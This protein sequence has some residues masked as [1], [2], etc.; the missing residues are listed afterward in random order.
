MKKAGV[1]FLLGLIILAVL[2]TAGCVK[3]V[4]EKSVLDIII[5]KDGNLSYCVGDTMTVNLPNYPIDGYSW[6]VTYSD[7]FDIQKNMVTAQELGLDNLY[8]SYTS[9]VFSPNEDAFEDITDKQ[10]A[11]SF[12]LKFMI[13]GEE[14]SAK[15]GYS[16]SMLVVNSDE[17][18]KSTFTYHGD[19]APQR[20]K[21]VSVIFQKTES[22]K[23]NK[24]MT[25]PTLITDGLTLKNT[26]NIMP[27][28][29]YGGEY[30]ATKWIVTSNDLGYYYFGAK[31]Y[32]PNGKDNGRKFYLLVTFG[33]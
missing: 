30:G 22:N 1:F 11:A 26:M 13:D 8:D 32:L 9:F 2:F 23:D 24:Y 21:N 18:T 10:G 14:E 17:H 27:G 4:D 6:E 15:Y 29:L 33:K 5:T 12:V 31:E 25:D 28:T 7:G 20:G 19:M 16:D 3:T